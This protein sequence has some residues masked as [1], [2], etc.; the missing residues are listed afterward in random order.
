KPGA[1]GRRRDGFVWTATVFGALASVFPKRPE[2]CCTPRVSSA[3]TCIGSKPAKTLAN[4]QSGAS[5]LEEGFSIRHPGVS[6]SAGDKCF[7]HR[8]TS[9]LDGTLSNQHPVVSQ[10]D[11]GFSIR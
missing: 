10:L 2:D 8:R 11:G 6:G 3:S 4:C 9:Q 5:Q 7:K 1:C